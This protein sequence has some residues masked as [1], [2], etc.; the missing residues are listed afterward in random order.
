MA[1]LSPDQRNYLYL[2]EAARTGIHKPILAALYT[3]H[4]QPILADEETG[5]GVSPANRIALEQVRTLGEQIYYAANTIRSLSESLVAQGWAA[6]DLWHAEKGRYTDRFIQTLAAG[7]AAPATES[8][9]A[10]LEACD[11]QKLLQAYGED[12]K[13]DCEIED[14][15]ENQA[16][17][18]QALL[19]LVSE[20]SRYYNGLPAQRD[21]LLE[22]ARIWSRLD[23]RE[24]TIA[25]LPQVIA[26][27]NIPQSADAY[28]ENSD[29][30]YLDGTLLQFVEQLSPN[31]T[32]YPHQREALLR[33]VQVWRQLDSREEAIVSLKKNTSAE[34][35]LKIL[36]PALI[37]FAGRI[38]QY[39]RGQAHQRNAVTEAVRIWRQLDSRTAALV[40]LGI[41]AENLEAGKSD[42]AVLVK[43]AAQL[44]REL[45]AFA[46]RLSIEYKEAD[47]QREALIVL[48]QR[49]RQMSTKTQAITSLFDDLKQMNLARRGSLEAAPTPLVI[50][51]KPPE[52]WTPKNIQ[53]Y[54]PII[55][56]GYFTWAE[57]THG[58]TR[59]PPDQATV[60]AMIRIAKLAQRARDRIGRPL[61]ITSWYR[62]AEINRRVGGVSNSRHIV[63]DAI[64]FYCEGLTGNQLYWFLD[65]WWPGGLG[66]YSCFPYL[67]HIDARNY[68]SRWL[69]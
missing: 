1:Q 22:T 28:A 29:E 4:N 55:P 56:D 63:G 2:Q 25:K 36:D 32:G 45:L 66:R 30:S 39:Y 53:M 57:A 9:A 14:F 49:W 40:S 8:T 38:P 7:Y 60:D 24:A 11:K 65:P 17:L 15:P 54:A 47:H 34:P 62:P 68:R 10:R 35:F 44:D 52:R 46:R 50:V 59:M 26:S 18:D 37:A 16:Y 5:L 69:N 13:I 67:S 51:P 64:D 19:T 20:L 6:S 3:A 58:G 43:A 33:L 27:L 42:P 48:V 21:A 41:K 31:Y 12:F 61:R 23:T